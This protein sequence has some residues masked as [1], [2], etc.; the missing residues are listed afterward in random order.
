MQNE[1][2]RF[3]V[4]GDRLLV[5]G[6]VYGNLHAF[7]ALM[8]EAHRLGIQP[9]EMICTG[10]LVAYCGN[11]GE[12]VD[13]FRARGIMTIMGNCEES[14]GAGSDD[15]GCGFDEGTACSLLSMQ[16][17]AFCQSELRSDQ[18]QW[19]AGLPR[20]LDLHFGP[21][22][23]L[24]VHGTATEINRFVFP[25]AS[26][27]DLLASFGAGSHQ[28]VLAG[29]SGIPFHRTMERDQT[30]P[31]HW[32]NSG[33]LGMPANDGT[34]RVWYALLTLKDDGALDVDLHALAYDYQAAAHVMRQKGLVNGYA[35]C[36][37][38][39]LWP[40]L[41]VLPSLDRDRTGQA[42]TF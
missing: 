19:M 30:R 21:H 3:Q 1:T 14:L 40:S 2:A 22:H 37:S 13:A 9:S 27:E 18:T 36:L 29:H 24:A 12:V 25:S 16:W 17:Y 8:A 4:P 34:S 33:A 26:D 7:D 15:C 10:D 42:L 41:D 39:G 11:P 38:S 6:G 35:D 32:I 5:F 20:T 31:K 23:L 28:A